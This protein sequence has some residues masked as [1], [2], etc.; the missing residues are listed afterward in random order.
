MHI[1]HGIVI[2]SVLLPGCGPKIVGLLGITDSDASDTSSEPIDPSSSTSKGARTTSTGTTTTSAST[3]TTGG[4]GT[5]TTGGED[6]GSP[7]IPPECLAIDHKACFD[8]AL[9][10]CAV[11]GSWNVTQACVDAVQDCYPIGTQKLVAADVIDFCHAEFPGDCLSKNDP[12]C[13]ETFC[14]CTAGAY[15]YDW[16]NC[17][18]L[19]LVACWTWGAPASDC[20]TVLSGCY[21]GATV[22]EYEECR[23]QALLEV[24]QEGSCYCPM[25]GHHEQ[26]EDALAACLGA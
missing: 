8:A 23:Y 17:W 16:N 13:S 18:H 19:L 12:G 6:S 11:F 5:T 24:G 25:C 1:R 21:P 3:S 2:L 7:V 14:A 26:C 4:E 20:E 15:P 22:S 10:A 9:D